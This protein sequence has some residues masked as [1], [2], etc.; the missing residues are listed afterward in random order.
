MRLLSKKRVTSFSIFHHA[1]GTDAMAIG[2]HPNARRPITSSPFRFWEDLV[3]YPAPSQRR[4]RPSSFYVFETR[5]MYVPITN[6][7]VRSTFGAT[8]SM[9]TG[10]FCRWPFREMRN[11]WEFSP[12]ANLQL[13]TV[14]ASKAECEER[15]SWICPSCTTLSLDKRGL[16]ALVLKAIIKGLPRTPLPTPTNVK[17]PRSQHSLP[18]P[19]C[20]DQSL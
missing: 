18:A 1:D 7:Y 6:T 19:T 4:S 3:L 16:A 2:S 14:R 8:R 17:L 5:P 11:T 20:R 10:D 9:L 12:L 13:W 15:L